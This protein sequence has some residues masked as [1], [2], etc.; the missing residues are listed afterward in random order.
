MPST[1]FRDELFRR[2]QAKAEAQRE[3]LADSAKTPVPSREELSRLNHDVTL[4]REPD[5]QS[6]MPPPSVRELWDVAY[7]RL[8]DEDTALVSSFEEGL[9]S[10]ANP[11][12]T[13]SGS[14]VS[15]REMMEGILKVKME[16]INEEVWKL[17]FGTTE[18]Q[19]KDMVEPVLGVVN[20]MNQYINDALS[21]NPYASL[22]WAGVSL[23]LPVGRHLK[24]G[25]RGVINSPL[26][27][28][29]SL[30]S[31]SRSRKGARIYF[32]PHHP[33][34]NVGGSVR[35]SLRNSACRTL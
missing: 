4:C 12:L 19:V 6:E 10:D 27:S 16:K 7:G 34:Q 9:R 2:R 21:S 15:R 24:R 18:V 31:G 17:R 23:L 25:R 30:N 14:K 22:A 35:S 32:Q 33:K 5:G 20:R 26:A 8:Q 1:G 11:G 28:P 29:Q 13:P 3:D